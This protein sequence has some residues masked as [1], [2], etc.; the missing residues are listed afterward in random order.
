MRSPLIYGYARVSSDGQSL[1]AQLDELKQ[2]GCERVFQE[3]I[4]GARSD[5]QELRKVMAKLDEGDVLIVSRLDRLARSSRDLL[6]ILHD[7]AA[8]GV[9]FRSIHDVWADTSTAHGRLMVTVLG[10][11]AEFERSLIIARTGEGRARAM[12]DGVRFGRKPKLT[13]HQRQE[14]IQRRES[15]E[16]TTAIARSFNVSHSTICRLK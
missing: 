2:A 8:K 13:A 16:T 4:S 15:G 14:A 7:V 9:T 11:L 3:K 6:N 12:R 5:R 1:D 10:G